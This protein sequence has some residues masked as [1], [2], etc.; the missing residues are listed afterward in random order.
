M[1]AGPLR[2]EEMGS[3]SRL[4][5]EASASPLAAASSPAGFCSRCEGSSSRL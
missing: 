5:W 1:V 3:E 2:S 4:D